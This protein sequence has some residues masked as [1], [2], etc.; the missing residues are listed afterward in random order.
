MVRCLLVMS[1][2]ISGVRF[3]VPGRDYL[4]LRREGHLAAVQPS[5]SGSEFQDAE[6]ERCASACSG[7]T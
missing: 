2:G 4:S 3:A 6:G 7:F 5:L 1:Q